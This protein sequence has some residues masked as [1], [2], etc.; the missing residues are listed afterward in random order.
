MT[1]GTASDSDF[2]DENSIPKPFPSLQKRF[3]FELKV[4]HQKGIKTAIMR[5]GFV[6]G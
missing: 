6:F 1:Y 5:P 3:D 2:L 4:L